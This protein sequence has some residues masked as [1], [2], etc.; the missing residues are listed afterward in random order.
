M[1]PSPEELRDLVKKTIVPH[2]E[3][4]AGLEVLE[5]IW[6]QHRPGDVGGV[7]ILRRSPQRQEFA[8]RSL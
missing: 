4:Q 2:T 8:F 7:A 5:E 1:K 3:F 6:E